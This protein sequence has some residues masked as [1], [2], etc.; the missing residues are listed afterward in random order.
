[1]WRYHSLVLLIPATL[2]S[3]TPSPDL[4]LLS[5][6]LRAR[7]DLIFFARCLAPLAGVVANS[8]PA[9][10]AWYDL[11]NAKTLLGTALPNHP[12]I[13][14]TDSSGG[15]VPTGRHVV[16]ATTQGY[17]NHDGEA[18]LFLALVSAAD[19]DEWSAMLVGAG[20][21]RSLVN[22]LQAYFDFRTAVRGLDS[23]KMSAAAGK[24]G[25]SARGGNSSSSSSSG[26][27]DS[28]RL[29]KKDARGEV[30]SDGCLGREL[31]TAQ[32]LVVVALG[33]LLSAH[34]LPARDR[35]QLSGGVLRLHRVIFQQP[36]N[37][38]V[39][40]A[41]ERAAFRGEG[42]TAA[43][44]TLAFPFLQEHCALVAMQV[45]RLCLRANDTVKELPPD[46]LE[47][48]VRL[49][50]TLAPSMR[51]TWDKGHVTSC[52]PAG[53]SLH[54][55]LPDG[56]EEGPEVGGKG[57]DRHG[58]LSHR[59]LPLGLLD[60]IPLPLPEARAASLSDSTGPAAEAKPSLDAS[61]YRLC[62]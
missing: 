15:V 50:G 13:G 43:A 5:F 31:E 4:R 33:A 24:S 55:V 14:E 20:L 38:H 32:V 21:V 52:G 57:C 42:C 18:A 12:W 34:P 27:T 19:K 26:G 51:T 1:M 23:T 54:A 37:S 25:P 28:F 3:I 7:Q 16:D 22:S 58:G 48:A 10:A 44:A 36:K 30:L 41:N 29:A 6:V 11:L 47:G 59:F 45:L 40:E 61:S 35:F 62:G 49:A 8:A 60:E 56:D 2:L 46:V 9:A 39:E 17:G 53:G